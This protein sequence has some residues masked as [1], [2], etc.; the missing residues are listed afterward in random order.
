MKRKLLLILSACMLLLAVNVWAEDGT[1]PFGDV[2]LTVRSVEVLDGQLT[3]AVD[4]FSN[5]VSIRDG[6]IVIPAWAYAMADDVRYDPV[7]VNFAANG[8]EETTSLTFTMPYDGLPDEI[9]L[10]P[11]DD[12]ENA[13]LLWNAEEAAEEAVEDATEE[14]PEE[15][16]EAAME[17]GAVGEDAENIFAEL[18]GTWHG[19]GVPTGGGPQIDLT[20]EVREDGTGEY[21]FLQAGYEESYPFTLEAEGQTFSVN[22]PADNVL[23]ITSCEGTYDLNEDGTLLLD[24]VTTFITGTQFS[25]NAECEKVGE[26]EPETEEPAAVEE[27]GLETEE[28]AAVEE[29]E[30]ETEEPAAVEEAESETE[31]PAADPAAAIE[32][33]LSMLGDEQYTDLFHFLEE[34][35]TVG[36]ESDAAY[37]KA[38]QSALIAL[39]QD[40]EADGIVGDKTIDALHAVQ[41]SLGLEISDTVGKEDLGKI[42]SAI[43]SKPQ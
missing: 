11:E 16:T 20:A 5:I 9:Y 19:T 25:Y 33:V 42:L 22:I 27:A 6:Q 2:N 26:A 10:Y 18:A 21:T 34:G 30:P 32:N 31:E 13:V 8:D 29:A 38:L 41:E 4:G 12:E 14:I 15:M 35:N 7:Q 23:H 36:R 17:E 28:P 37:G 39:G 40:I 43:A 3:V 1:I 24:I